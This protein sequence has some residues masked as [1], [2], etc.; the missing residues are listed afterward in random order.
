MCVCVLCFAT[1]V[2]SPLILNCIS[3][4]FE[5]RFRDE[6]FN[7]PFLKRS[8]IKTRVYFVVIEMLTTSQI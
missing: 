4:N 1:V 3:D 7:P 6:S 5:I 2:I 8:L